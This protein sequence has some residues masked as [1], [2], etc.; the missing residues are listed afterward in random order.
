MAPCAAVSSDWPGIPKNGYWRWVARTAQSPPSSSPDE[1]ALLVQPAGGRSRPKVAGGDP[2]GRRPLADLLDVVRAWH[3]EQRT[4]IAVLH[5]LEQ[6][7]T[8]FPET[9]LLAR[10]G[11]AWGQTAHVL[12]PDNLRRARRMAEAWDESAPPCAVKP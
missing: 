12:T 9:L 4:V 2:P 11:I 10:S 6:V 5:D 1:A 7:R 8:H 3:A